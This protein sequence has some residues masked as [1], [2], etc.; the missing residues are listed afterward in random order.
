[1]P[2]ILVFPQYDNPYLTILSLAPQSQGYTV[3]SELTL[4]K[5]IDRLHSLKNGDT[6]HLHWTAPICQTATDADAARKNLDTFREATRAA[7]GRGV[8]VLW[9]VHNTLPHELTYRELEIELCEFLASTAT[10]VIQLS[11]KTADVV[12]ET[13]TLPPDRLVTLPLS[14][15]LGVYPISATRAE[16]R[17]HFGLDEDAGPVIVFV[18]QIRPYKGLKTLFDA[19]EI[20]TKQYPKIALLVAGNTRAEARAELSALFPPSAQVVSQLTF[21]AD[22]EIQWWFTAADIAVFPYQAILNSSSVFL[23]A[24]FGRPCIIPDGEPLRSQFE[25]EAWVTRYPTGGGAGEE[26]ESLAR[27]ISASVPHTEATG[28]AAFRFARAHLPFELSLTYLDLLQSLNR[29]NEVTAS[30]ATLA[31]DE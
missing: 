20:L 12:S 23:S 27:A 11:E 22:E 30:G 24:T 5:L 3:V 28:Q 17:E 6:F 7:L 2:T 18:G 29:A 10:R 25:G 15:Y 4:T 14:S 8:T 16:A 9:T 21:V 13:Y 19:V 26:A 31:T 1:M